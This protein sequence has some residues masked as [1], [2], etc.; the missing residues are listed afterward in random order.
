M[1]KM[2]CPGYLC[3]KTHECGGMAER[4]CTVFIVCKKDVTNE[5]L[6]SLQIS[7]I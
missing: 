3:W 2:I 6:L 4:P 1:K 7:Q 5:Y